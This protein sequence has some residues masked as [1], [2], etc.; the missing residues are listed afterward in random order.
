MDQRG[1]S[2]AAGG[3]RHGISRRRLIGTG[4][5]AGAGASIAGVPAAAARRRRPKHR[6]ADVAIV[7]AGFAGLTAARRLHEGGAKV[8]V[9]EARDRVGGRAHNLAIGGGEITELGAT[10]I[11][12][13]QDRIAAL[14]QEVG[15]GTFPTY[16]TGNNIYL[17][18]SSR[19]EFSDTGITGTAPPDPVILPD[20]ALTIAR[21]DQM[22]TEVPVDAPWKAARAAEYDSQTLASWIDANSLTPQFKELVKVATRPIFGADPDELSLLYVLFYIA[23][24]GNES[25]VGTFER[26]FN[27]RGGAQETRFKGGSQIICDRIAK[28]FGKR[29]VLRSPVSK[30]TQGKRGVVVHSRKVVVSADRVIVAIPPTLTGEIKFRPGLPDQRRGLVERL[31]QGQLTKVTAIYDRPFWRDQGLTGQVISDRAP[32]NVTFDDSPESGT[33]GVVFGFVGGDSARDFAKL[34]A[35]GRRA[36]ALANLAEYFGGQ[37]ANPV[38]YHETAWKSERWTR[39]CPVAIAGPGVLTRYGEALRAPVGRVHWA[40]TETSTFWNGYM[41]GAVRSGE[42]AAQEVLDRL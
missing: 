36:A 13:T 2:D 40:G 18:G 37:A 29:V 35:A 11:G 8:I 9:L 5:A 4:V 23:A 38:A 42:R 22:A 1:R 19:L 24:S 41:D 25:N 31:P 16:D 20:L 33:P 39:G 7:G 32:L 14:A 17:S 15:V 34:D 28:A 6:K 26:N 30:I 3:E 10:F 27:T 12:P 21:L